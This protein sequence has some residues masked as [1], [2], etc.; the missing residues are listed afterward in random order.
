MAY[1]ANDPINANKEYSSLVEAWNIEKRPDL[2]EVH[3]NEMTRNFVSQMAISLKEYGDSKG[4]TFPS[5]YAKDQ[6]YGDLAWGGFYNTKAFKELSTSEQSRI[7]DTIS[8]EQTG[9]NISGVIQTKNGTSG[10]SL[11]EEY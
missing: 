4:Y 5:N 8:V 2:N 10:G 6:F 11:D 1:F 7:K 9:K 3:H